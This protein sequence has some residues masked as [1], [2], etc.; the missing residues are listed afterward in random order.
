MSMQVPTEVVRFGVGAPTP[1]LTQKYF[2]LLQIAIATRKTQKKIQKQDAPSLELHSLLI[3]VS[4]DLKKLNQK[5]GLP[6]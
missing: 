2:T 1:P 3:R 4:E 6:K 5:Y